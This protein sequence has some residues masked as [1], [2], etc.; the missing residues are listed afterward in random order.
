MMYQP[1]ANIQANSV[2][3]Y[4]KLPSNLYLMWALVYATLTHIE[5]LIMQ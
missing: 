1:T 5:H 2:K 4:Y 3:M